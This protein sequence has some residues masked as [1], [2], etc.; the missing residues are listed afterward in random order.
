[1]SESARRITQGLCGC[2]GGFREARDPAGRMIPGVVCEACG[3]SWDPRLGISLEVG[4]AAWAT[5]L[6][7]LEEE[8]YED[9]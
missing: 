7:D 6:A 4:Y 8:P 5:Y 1:M 9:R 3:Y 2:G